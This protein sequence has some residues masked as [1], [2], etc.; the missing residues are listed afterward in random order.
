MIFLKNH[1]LTAMDYTK[2]HGNDVTNIQDH[3]TNAHLWR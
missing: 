1:G 2:N 3:L